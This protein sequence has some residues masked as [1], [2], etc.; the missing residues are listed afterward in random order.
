M[1]QYSIHTMSGLQYASFDRIRI[2]R[3][4]NLKKDRHLCFLYFF[5][6]IE[7]VGYSFAYVA[8]L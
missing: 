7:S 4:T 5:G 1:R 6:G 3:K 2:D 8:L